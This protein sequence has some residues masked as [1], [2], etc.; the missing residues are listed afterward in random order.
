MPSLYDAVIAELLGH[1]V[2]NIISDPTSA[3]YNLLQDHQAQE[4]E[5]HNYGTPIIWAKI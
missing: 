1:N 2:G 3:P 5:E 4:I